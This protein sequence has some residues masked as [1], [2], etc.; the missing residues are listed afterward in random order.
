[1][2]RDTIAVDCL[3]LVASAMLFLGIAKTSVIDLFFLKP[4]CWLESRFLSSRMYIYQ[5]FIYDHFLH[6]QLVRDIGRFFP[7]F[8]TEIT[9]A[10]LHSFGK[11]PLLHMSSYMPTRVSRAFRSIFFS[12]SHN[13]CR[14]VLLMIL[15]ILKVPRRV[16]LL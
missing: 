13:G 9:F 14:L 1:M 2:S 8:S 12:E 4:Y 16:L 11:L 3:F 6:R 10:L 15:C 7:G 5:S